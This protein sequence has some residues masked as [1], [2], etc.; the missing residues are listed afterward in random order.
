MTNG[1]VVRSSLWFPILSY[2]LVA[3]PPDKSSLGGSF[4]NPWKKHQNLVFVGEGFDKKFPLHLVGAASEIV[5][6]RIEKIS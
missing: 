4:R 6:D 5:I 2:S 1:V 3:T